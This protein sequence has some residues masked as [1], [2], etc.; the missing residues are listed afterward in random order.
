VL[1]LVSELALCCQ[2]CTLVN[3]VGSWLC[4]WSICVIFFT[5][6]RDKARLVVTVQDYEWPR[7]S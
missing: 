7:Q 3:W 2:A 1:V 5:Y 6:T 4:R